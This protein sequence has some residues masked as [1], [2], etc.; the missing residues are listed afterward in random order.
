MDRKQADE[1]VQQRL[2]SIFQRGK[3]E[4]RLIL[5]ISV[6]FNGVNTD[7]SAISHRL[8]SRSLTTNY[9]NKGGLQG[10]HH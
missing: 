9:A 5:S 7:V 6:E 10:Q 4:K 8:G 2:D 1:E 3:S